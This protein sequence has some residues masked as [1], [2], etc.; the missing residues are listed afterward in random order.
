MILVFFIQAQLLP[1]SRG[2]SQGAAL[3]RPRSEWDCGE[4]GNDGSLNIRHHPSR[5]VR[6]AS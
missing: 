1:S 5:V 6:S 4:I 3:P 2:A